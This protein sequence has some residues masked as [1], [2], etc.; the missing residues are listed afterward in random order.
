[1]PHEYFN[2]ELCPAARRALGF[3]PEPARTVGGCAIHRGLAQT[4]RAGRRFRHQA[5]VSA[6]RSGSRNRA[7][8]DLFDGATVIH[9][10]RS[11]RR[12]N[13]LRSASAWKAATGISRA[14]RPRRRLPATRKT[15]TDFSVQALQELD[16]LMG[17]DAGFRCLFT[18]ARHQTHLR[19]IGRIVRRTARGHRENSLCGGAC[20]SIRTNS[21]RPLR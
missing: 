11:T 7:G 16:M 18:L 6:F 8:R 20:R 17:Q 19:H 3:C 2:S 4:P 10:F 21:T 1:M 13:M 14:A 5:A 9:L 12:L 15:S